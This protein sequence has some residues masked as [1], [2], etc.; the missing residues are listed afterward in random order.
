MADNTVSLDAAGTPT[1]SPIIQISTSIYREIF[2]NTATPSST[3]SSEMVPGGVKPEVVPVP[4]GHNRIPVLSIIGITLG[5]TSLLVIILGML[6]LLVRR[7]N[8]P[9]HVPHRESVVLYSFTHPNPKSNPNSNS[10]KDDTT[11]GTIEQAEFRPLNLYP[12]RKTDV[13]AI[14]D[15]SLAS[16][17]TS[18]RN[19]EAE[20]VVPVGTGQGERERERHESVIQVVGRSSDRL[21]ET[22]MGEASAGESHRDSRPLGYAQ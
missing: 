19:Y 9:Y 20:P 11:V 14:S 16:M 4:R 21:S 18:C 10:I 12:L 5:A 1:I 17:Y 2:T 3:A 22:V 7:R 8:R 6:F 15:H 13:G